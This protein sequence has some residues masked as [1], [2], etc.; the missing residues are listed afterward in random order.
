MFDD[1]SGISGWAVVLTNPEND[2]KFYFKTLIKKNIYNKLIL[3][4]IKI[5]YTRYLSKK[6]T[7]QKMNDNLIV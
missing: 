7:Y 2:N 6:E 1:D 3:K 4:T 5:F